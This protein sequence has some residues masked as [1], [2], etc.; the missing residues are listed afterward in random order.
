MPPED[1]VPLAPEISRIISDRPPHWESKLLQSALRLAA[2]E[3][4]SKFDTATRGIDALA[5]SAWVRTFLPLY[6]QLVGESLLIKNEVATAFGSPSKPAD[7]D[8][9]VKAV[10]HLVDLTRDAI[11]LQQRAAVLAQHPVFGALATPLQ[12]MAKP[13]VDAYN[14]LLDQ[15]DQQL[16]NIDTTH[17]LDL[18]LTLKA[19]PSL[20]GFADAFENYITKFGLDQNE[21][22]RTGDVVKERFH[23]ARG[24]QQLGEF[25]RAAI[26]DNLAAGLFRSDDWYWS[27]DSQQWKPLSSLR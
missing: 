23:I 10:N 18:Q 6:K 7:P 15:L 21:R 3:L 17:H 22:L 8:L 2:D 1:P 5:F 13:F 24:E 9:I 19:P 4:N 12:D 25:G 14:D 11:I 27:G 26:A 20:D 16:P